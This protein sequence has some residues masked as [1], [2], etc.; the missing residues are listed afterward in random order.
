[1]NELLNTT[2]HFGHH[3]FTVLD[4]VEVVA[5]VFFAR[6]I[7]ALLRRALR[8]VVGGGPCY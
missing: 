1:M 5:V 2:F 8:R 6:L 3:A 7:L 4:I